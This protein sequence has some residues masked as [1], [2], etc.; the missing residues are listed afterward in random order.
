M[1][2]RIVEVPEPG[3]YAISLKSESRAFVRLHEAGIIDGDFV[4]K[5][6]V[7]LPEIELNLGAGFH[8]LVVSGLTTANDTFKF[9]IRFRRIREN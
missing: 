9:S 4:K 3:R 2:S 1:V 5:R 7:P 8:P 6:M